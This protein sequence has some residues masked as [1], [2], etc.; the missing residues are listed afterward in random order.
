LRDR[1]VGVPNPCTASATRRTSV[2]RCTCRCLGSYG[3]VSEESDSRVAG[4]VH[5]CLRCVAFAAES[6]RS[7]RQSTIVH[8]KEGK[9]YGILA[10]VYGLRVSRKS[11]MGGPREDRSRSSKVLFSPNR[12][13][14]C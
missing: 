8:K 11:A 13:Y 10:E 9:K 4:V 1:A 7:R 5:F 14:F 2:R 6:E 3:S 12:H